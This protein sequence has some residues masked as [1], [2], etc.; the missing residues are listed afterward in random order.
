M[1]SVYALTFIALYPVTTLTLTWRACWFTY[2]TLKYFTPKKNIQKIC[3]TH[4]KIYD[5]IV[6]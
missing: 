1:M 2:F 4:E 6:V 5:F 3:D